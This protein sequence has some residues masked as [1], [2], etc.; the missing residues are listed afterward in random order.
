[1][2]KIELNIPTYTITMTIIMTKIFMKVTFQRMI[3]PPT[4][5]P[6]LTAIKT[7]TCSMKTTTNGPP[8]LKNMQYSLSDYTE[9][10]NCV[11]YFK[12]RIMTLRY[13]IKVMAINL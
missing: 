10:K 13:M 12:K 7:T 3:T 2:T 9:I 11:T 4:P 8:P 5:P 6:L 1:M